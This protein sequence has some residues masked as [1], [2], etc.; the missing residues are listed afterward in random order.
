MI[1]EAI[2]LM[3]GESTSFDVVY[4]DGSVKRFDIL[5]ISDKYPQLIQLKDRSLFEKGKLLGWSGISWNDD[6]DI[7]VDTVYKHGIDVTDEYD[8]SEITLFVLGYKIKSKRLELFMS[9]EELASKAG[10]DQSDL[11]KIEKGLLNP[12]IKM[13]DRI[14]KG[15]N[16]KTEI[17]FK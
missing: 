7:D 5:S 6:L 12:S 11:S 1:N 17:S 15:L 8:S 14:A 16:L 2:K 3:F 4:L 9:Q 10:I 13:I